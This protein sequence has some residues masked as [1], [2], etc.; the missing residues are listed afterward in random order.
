MHS[1]LP[2]TLGEGNP[3]IVRRGCGDAH[4]FVF[5]RIRRCYLLP[6]STL[7]LLGHLS[8]SYILALLDLCIP[9]T[10]ARMDVKY[11]AA[12]VDLIPDFR[13]HTLHDK[14]SQP[15]VI[16]VTASSHLQVSLGSG[17]RM[18]GLNE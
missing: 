3:G 5:I 16:P 14:H 18:R 1:A 7:D 17:T 2:L 11:D 9:L 8:T 10:I 12:S 15:V 6:P 13:D 4:L